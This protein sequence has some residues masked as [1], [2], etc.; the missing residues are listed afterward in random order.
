MIA[1]YLNRP[2]HLIQVKCFVGQLLGLV[3][4]LLGRLG[5][6][7]LE[8]M[9]LVVSLLVL[10]LEVKGQL[11]VKQALQLGLEAPH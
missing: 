11:L 3:P 6:R 2:Q 5:V 4:E 1:G 10:P 9:V 8:L 7:Q